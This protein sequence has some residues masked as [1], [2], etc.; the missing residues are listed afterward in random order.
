MN[1]LAN[2]MKGGN[3]VVFALVGLFAVIVVG[4]IIYWIYKAIKKAKS[5][6]DMNPILVDKPIDPTL[7][8]N[9]KSWML[10]VTSSSNTPSL[11][12]TLSYW[13]YISNWNYRYNEPKCTHGKSAD[14]KSCPP[15]ADSQI[16]LT[17]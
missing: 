6:D 7:P 9:A 10:P 3:S 1:R 17:S 13:M 14:S 11:T 8:K 5:G 2:Y 15:A 4:M 16:I 12:F